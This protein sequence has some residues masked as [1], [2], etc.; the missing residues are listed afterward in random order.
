MISVKTRPG[1]R[2]YM[3]LGAME[4]LGNFST[5]SLV[6]IR[7]AGY[8]GVQFISPP[9]AEMLREARSMGLGVCGS[10]RVNVLGEGKFLPGRH[11]I[12]T[13]NA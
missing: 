9:S 5:K 1:L 2:C 13:W 6:S 10:G 11:A 8:Q 12:R 4:G 3:N 7:E